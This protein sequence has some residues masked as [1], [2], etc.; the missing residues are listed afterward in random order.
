MWSLSLLLPLACT[1]NA[2]SNFSDYILAPDSRTVYPATIH[3]VNGSVS[4]ANSLLA[5]P[6]GNATLRGNSSI[7]FDYSKNV[8]GVVS[9]TVA[10]TDLPSDTVLG[11]TFT[12]SSLWINGQASDATADAGLDS[13]LWLHVG[14]DGPGTYTVGPEFE[15]GAFRYLSLVSNSSVAVQVTSVAVNF[16]AAPTQNL[17]EYSGYFHSDDELLNRVW[18][19]GESLKTLGLSRKEVDCC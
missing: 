15:R 7:T 14:R 18:Y 4:N 10:S 13:P 5:S 3:R 12:E 1:A 19:A 9:V 6:N 2:A 11:V 16:T 17:R 8:G